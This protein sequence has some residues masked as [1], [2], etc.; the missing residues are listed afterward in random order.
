MIEFERSFDYELIRRIMT[1]S[2]SIYDRISDDYSPPREQFRPHESD[3]IWY[4]I[5]RDGREVLGMW[6]FAPQNAVTWEVHTVLLPC[7]WGARG[8]QAALELPDWIWEHTTCRRIVTSVPSNNR[9]ALKFA[10]TAQ[11]RVYGINEA[12]YLKNGA[13]LDQVCLGISA[14]AE[15]SQLIETQEETCQPL[16]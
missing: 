6:M 1:Y 13:L 16:Q 7:A 14:P 11:M 5:V 15:A 3:A 10:I 8:M 9:L 2:Q 4:V 12:S